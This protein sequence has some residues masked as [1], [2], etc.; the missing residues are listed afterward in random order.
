MRTMRG[1]SLLTVA[2]VGVAFAAPASAATLADWQMNEAPG[3]HTMVDSSGHVNGSIGSA[4]T[5]RPQRSGCD[6][7]SLGIR[8]SH[9]AAAQAGAA[10]AG[11]QLVAEPGI[12]KLHGR[13]EVSN[14]AALRQH[15]AEGPGRID[16]AGTSRSRTPAVISTASSGARSNGTLKRKA[17]ESPAVLSDNSWHVVVCAGRRP[18]LTLKI[19]G[20][21]VDTASGKHRDDLQHAA[22]HDRR[23][24][25]LRPDHDHLRLLHRRYRLHQDHQLAS[26]S[27]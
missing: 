13:D 6:R 26:W 20:T 25:Q 1:T 5:D 4:V 23:Q 21:V 17:V 14:D 2:L 18:K 3:A 8:E 12:G 27:E 10:G 16:R 24:A 22:D 7:L 11:T 19:D 9:H 15:G